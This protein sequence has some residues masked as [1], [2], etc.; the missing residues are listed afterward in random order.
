MIT[1]SVAEPPELGIVLLFICAILITLC[2]TLFAIS[3][4]S[5]K[6]WARVVQMIAWWIMVMALVDFFAMML[7]VMFWI[8][9]TS[10]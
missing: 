6:D 10:I 9:R 5:V 2:V 3:A 8:A 4:S 1:Q 7:A